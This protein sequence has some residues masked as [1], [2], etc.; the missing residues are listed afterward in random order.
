[1]I[2]SNDEE[3]VLVSSGGVLYRVGEK[4]YEV[5]LIAKRETKIWALPRGRVEPGETP[6]ETAI[7]EIREE[8]GFVS[9][10]LEK[11]DEIHF[12]FYSR[13]D[14]RFI[15]RIVHFYLMSCEDGEPGKLDEEVDTAEWYPMER[16]VRTLKYENEKEILRKAKRILEKQKGT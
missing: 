8:T 14:D 11:I 2:G 5:C 1:M 15:R 7:R 13:S 9:K 16:A 12:Q 3:S 4:Q 6:P 10:I